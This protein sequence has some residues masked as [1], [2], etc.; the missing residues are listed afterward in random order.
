MATEYSFSKFFR[1]LPRLALGGGYALNQYTAFGNLSPAYDADGNLLSSTG[2][3]LPHRFSTK[4]YD[5]ETGL[6]YYGYRFYSP[7]LKRWLNRDPIGEDGCSNVY[8][9]VL[10]DPICSIDLL[11]LKTE[12]S[13]AEKLCGKWEIIQRNI[14]VIK[15]TEQD[16]LG[17]LTPGFSIRFIPDADCPCTND[18][19]RI[20]NIQSIGYDVDKFLHRKARKY[21][22]DAQTNEHIEQQGKSKNKLPLDYVEGGGR[23]YGMTKKGKYQQ[24]MYGYSDAPYNI[25]MHHGVSLSYARKHHFEDTVFEIS[26]CAVYTDGIQH[27]VIGCANFTWKDIE[28]K[29]EWRD[30]ESTTTGALIKASE[31]PGETW[32]KALGEWNSL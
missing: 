4:Y 26:S 13:V 12:I 23:V 21:A 28:R 24:V 18:T 31:I 22:F 1:G 2:I 7:L 14:R 9:F 25:P 32:K 17:Y 19:K 16:V 27:Q 3:A 20:K 5:A 10:N 30:A 11:G 15:Q 8:Q 6:Y 29:V